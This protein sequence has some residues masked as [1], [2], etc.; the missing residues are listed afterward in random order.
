M[1]D[2]GPLRSSQTIAAA[3]V[4]ESAVVRLLNGV[5][6]KVEIIPELR[7]S[8]RHSSHTEAHILPHSDDRVTVLSWME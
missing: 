3:V 6:L 4:G 7:I 2:G 8:S 1:P 5:R